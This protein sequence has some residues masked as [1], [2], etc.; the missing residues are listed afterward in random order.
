MKHWNDDS[1]KLI[2]SFDIVR[3]VNN[4]DEYVITLNNSQLKLIYMH[5]NSNWK[6]WIRTLALSYFIVQILQYWVSIIML[7]EKIVQKVYEIKL[8]KKMHS[9]LKQSLQATNCADYWACEHKLTDY[10]DN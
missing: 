8:N 6:Q 7:P 10:K 4:E 3:T 2:I 1:L 5:S 9:I